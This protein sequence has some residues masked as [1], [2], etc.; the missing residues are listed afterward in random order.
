M[1]TKLKE[2]LES[3]TPPMIYASYDDGLE[4]TYKGRVRSILSLVGTL[5]LAVSDESGIPLDSLYADLVSS[6]T[7]ALEE[8]EE[9]YKERKAGMN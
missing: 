2:A 8:L 1:D 7:A 4:I 6:S 3:K 5:M 9:K